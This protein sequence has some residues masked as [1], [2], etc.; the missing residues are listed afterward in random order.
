MKITKF[1]VCKHCRVI[2]KKIPKYNYDTTAPTELIY[3]ENNG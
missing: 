1:H 2:V 3:A